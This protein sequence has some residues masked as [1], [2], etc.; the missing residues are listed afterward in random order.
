[1]AGNVVLLVALEGAWGSQPCEQRGIE[2]EHG[3]L[4]QQKARYGA[5]APPMAALQAPQA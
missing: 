2:T 3:S 1:V 4:V 5:C